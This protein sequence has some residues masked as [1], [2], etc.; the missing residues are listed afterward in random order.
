MSENSSSVSVTISEATKFDGLT[1]E[2]LEAVKAN[3][4]EIKISYDTILNRNRGN[5]KACGV[6]ELYLLGFTS[7]VVTTINTKGPNEERTK[8]LVNCVYA[9]QDSPVGEETKYFSRDSNARSSI[10]IDFDTFIMIYTAMRLHPKNSFHFYKSAKRERVF[11]ELFLM[12]IRELVE[13]AIVN[14]SQELL[15]VD[16]LKAKLITP[17]QESD[18]TVSTA[19]KNSCD[20]S[21]PGI[22]DQLAP[23]P[24]A[25]TTTTTTTTA[26]V[27]EKSPQEPEPEPE[28]DIEKKT[29]SEIF[30]C[31]ASPPQ[32]KCVVVT[33]NPD[34]DLNTSWG[35]QKALAGVYFV[36]GPPTP[37]SYTKRVKCWISTECTLMCTTKGEDWEAPYTEVCMEYGNYILKKIIN[38]EV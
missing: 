26:T 2:K 24:T 28:P 8:K 22:G 33:K 11:D 36:G 7:M 13:P 31:S 25:T 17:V 4:R 37:N 35:R 30:K 3:T 5:V 20:S 16:N 32:S 21:S 27:Q 10:K 14:N 9:T 29:F 34:S 18:T 15:H 1:K 19:S 12:K 6:L 23:M 38:N